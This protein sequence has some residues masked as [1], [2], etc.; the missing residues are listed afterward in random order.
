M[1]CLYRELGVSDEE[2]A[3]CG[4]NLGSKL[5]KLEEIIPLLKKKYQAKV[6]LAAAWGYIN[7]ERDNAVSREELEKFLHREG[8]NFEDAG[9]VSRKAFHLA[10]SKLS[11]Y[12]ELDKLFK[13]FDSDNNGEID[14]AEF[15]GVV[16]PE[17]DLQGYQSVASPSQKT[18]VANQNLKVEKGE[19]PTTGGEQPEEKAESPKKKSAVPSQD[20]VPVG[21][22]P[23]G[24]FAFAFTPLR[25]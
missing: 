8:F 21:T 12:V 17:E 14:F 15:T 4:Q 16:F 2:I 25:V 10:K 7:E 13:H 1:V 3:R 24:P 23:R 18:R 11:S 20:F 9:N 22:Y 6:S 19:E 5:W